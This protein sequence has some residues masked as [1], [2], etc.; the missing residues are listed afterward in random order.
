MVAKSGATLK[1]TKGNRIVGSGSGRYGSGRP[2]AAK[3]TI[4]VVPGPDRPRSAGRR[5][6]TVFLRARQ[7]SEG[8][9]IRR[10]SALSNAHWHAA[11][12]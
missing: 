12:I 8:S 5:P 3:S 1:L 7:G 6:L 9:A 11:S 10:R 4:K 2:Q